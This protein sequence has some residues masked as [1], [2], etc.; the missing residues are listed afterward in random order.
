M[1]TQN[2]PVHVKLWHKDFWILATANML[3]AMF[4]YMQLTILPD[5]MSAKLG[6]TDIEIGV[7]MG[8]HG[9]G[10]FMLGCF[11]TFLI[12]KY[13]RHHVC[14]SAI[15]VMV[16]VMAGY[17]YIFRY[18]LPQCYMFAAITALR[19][20]GGAAFGM[21]E[22]VLLS[23]L[24]IDKCESFRRTEAN[25]SAA[26]FS[27]FALSLGPA[28]SAVVMS[29]SELSLLFIVI[30]AVGLAAILL[31]MTVDF[32]FKAPEDNIKKFSLDRFFFVRGKW[33]FVNLLLIATVMGLL[34]SYMQSLIFYGMLMIGFFL[35]L[36]AQ[37][38]VFVNAELKSE[39]TAGVILMAAGIMTM[40][41]PDI[42]AV[43]I[44]SP[45]LVGCGFGLASSRF[46][47]FFIKLTQH[48]QR[49]T[50]QSTYFLSCEAG[51]SV[52][53]FVGYAFVKDI[54]GLVVASLVALAS[55]LVMYLCF[56]HCW[57]MANKN[58]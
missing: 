6:F 23:T 53:L 46:L 50:V 42:K 25:H 19:L 16:G 49:G 54:A 45:V 26:W 28:V 37:R 47:L 8:I 13:R 38:F 39:V 57:Y 32:P 7:A 55:A 36:L 51:L 34:F 2:T 30:A 40:L 12:Q 5:W 18:G 35:A 1:Y 9:A 14:I 24:I 33:L 10:A 43:G 48:C 56:T 27:R 41:S 11:C 22:M 29:L 52:G 4:A 15:A 17:Y 31:I 20:I 21:A 58:R 44:V 3:I